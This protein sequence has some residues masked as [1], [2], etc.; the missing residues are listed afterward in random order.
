MLVYL[1]DFVKTRY[2]HLGKTRKIY[3]GQ[4]EADRSQRSGE[5][6]YVLSPL[7]SFAILT[8][9]TFVTSRVD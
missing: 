7:K 9:T 5:R 2:S 8:C 4:N 3:C 1:V 6:L